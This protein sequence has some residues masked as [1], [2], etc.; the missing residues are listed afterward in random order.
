MTPRE[1]VPRAVPGAEPATERRTYRAALTELRSRQ[2]TSKGAP[3][4][5]RFVNRPLGR[6]LA[7]LAYVAGL[8]PDQVTA[9]SA[10]ATFAGIGLV[11]LAPPTVAIGIAV[12]ALLVLGYALD[13]ADGQV[14]RL[15]G[16]GSPAGEWLD[17][18][19]DAVKLGLLHLAV[20][21][22]WY[23]HFDVPDTA[24]LIPLGFLVVQSVLFFAMV[25]TDALR[26]AHRGRRE[27]FLTG[28]GSSSA[29]YSLAVVPTDYGLVCLLFALLGWRTGFLVGYTLL[30]VATAGFT[31]LALP[32]WYLELRRLGRAEGP[33]E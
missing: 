4:Y 11:A 22:S 16:G 10:L 2:K 21:V 26:R 6:R 5:S 25:L 31:L 14:A 33:V 30:G 7:A 15:R 27:H 23:R 18:V 24:L 28:D 32:K 29:L 9:L 19:V 12:A 3:A 20:L 1:S 13:S 8:S 17:H